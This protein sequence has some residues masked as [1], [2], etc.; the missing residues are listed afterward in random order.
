MDIVAQ[1]TLLVK[2]LDDTNQ[3]AITELAANI[4]QVER[5]GLL[6]DNMGIP[7]RCDGGYPLQFWQRLEMALGVK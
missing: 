4:E 1:I 7:R 2:R 3:Q 5:F 6:M